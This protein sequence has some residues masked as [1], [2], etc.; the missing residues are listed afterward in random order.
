MLE[1][2][3]KGSHFHTSGHD[4]IQNDL[5]YSTTQD[6]ESSEENGSSGK[7]SSGNKLDHSTTGG[8]NNKKSSKDDI[9][10]KDD[11]GERKINSQFQ[12]MATIKSEEDNKKKP[13]VL[14]EK[15]TKNLCRAQG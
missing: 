12:K 5:A 13:A 6:D 3:S 10:S 7:T 4:D 8:T 1:E 15:N 2:P 14:K 11:E 9:S